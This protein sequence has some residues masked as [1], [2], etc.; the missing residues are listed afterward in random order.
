MFESVEE[1]LRV[2]RA[3]QQITLR[4]PDGGINPPVILEDAR[5]GSEPRTVEIRTDSWAEYVTVPLR[6][7]L[8]IQ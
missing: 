2:L 5:A 4:T 8:A 6:D 7:I 3:G 1:A